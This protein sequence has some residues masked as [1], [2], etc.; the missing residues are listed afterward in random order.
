MD[1]EKGKMILVVDNLSYYLPELLEILDRLGVEHRSKRYYELD[2]GMQHQVYDGMILSGRRSNDRIMNV[3]NMKLVR[4]AY[5][6]DIPLLGICYGL[7][8]I[9]LALNG[10]IKRN[11]RVVGFNDVY[12]V[13]DNPLI[14]RGVIR[15]YENHNYA[16]ATLPEGFISIACSDTCR[17]E[18]VMHNQKSV[19]GV[20]FHPEASGT[21][22]MDIIKRFVDICYRR[23]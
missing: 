20:Q 7:E 23:S 10:T 21:Y 14:D 2:L 8:I 16:T 1:K 22:G 17:N 15:V 19:F 13:E 6:N 18:A 3:V 5:T 4:Y 11:G 12:V 9:A